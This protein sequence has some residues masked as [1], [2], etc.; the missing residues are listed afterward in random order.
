MNKEEKIKVIS[1]TI[2]LISNPD[3]WIRNNLA[4]D[5]DDYVVGPRDNS[6]C[7]WCA[8]GAIYKFTE[9]DFNVDEL[10]DEIYI[11]FGKTLDLINDQYGR[12]EV[13]STM[14]EYKK[15]LI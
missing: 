2:E 13:I 6:A 8:I 3:S 11:K 15:S 7:K 12:E 14:Q 9:F 5:I 1:Q 10:L 4:K